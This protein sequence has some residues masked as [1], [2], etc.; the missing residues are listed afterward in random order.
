MRLLLAIKS[1]RRDWLRGDHD[2]I[3]NTW[4]RDVPKDVDLRF[5]IGDQGGCLFADLPDEVTLFC[6]DDYDNLPQKSRE[7]FKWA[8]KKGY[9]YVFI[10]DTDTF[11]IPKRLIALPFCNFDL[12]GRFGKVKP[13]GQTFRYIDGRDIVYDPCWP[14][15]SGGCG[16]FVSRKGA[17]YIIKTNYSGWAEDMQSGQILGPLEKQQLVKIGD[18]EDLE[19]HASWHFPRW[20]YNQ[21]VYDPKFGWQELMY[22]EHGENRDSH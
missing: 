15:P 21:H 12:A 11:V 19:C 22:R 6:G 4:G 1:C 2:V 18:L 20:K 9:D 16:Y 8:L 5:F 7:I 17:D 10:A 3:R 14:W 13:I